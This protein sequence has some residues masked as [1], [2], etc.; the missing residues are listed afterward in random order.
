MRRR[1]W[2]TVGV[3]LIVTFV[4]GL[5]IAFAAG[6]HRTSTA[7][8]RYTSD[9]GGVA[10]ARIIQDDR[11]KPLTPK[12][13]ALPGVES[14][15]SASFVFGG[16]G[17]VGDNGLDALVF[18][19][20]YRISGVRLVEGRAASPTDEHEFV[21]TRK[22]AHVSH[23]QIGDK[24]NLVTMT[25]EQAF[26]NGYDLSDP[27]GPR[28][29]IEMVGIVDGAS[30]LDDGSAIVFVSPALLAENIGLSQTLMNVDLRPG[31]DLTEFRAQLDAA[32]GLSAL[33][34]E[35][36]V[37]ISEAVR[38]AVDAQ[39]RGLWILTAV[40]AIAAVAVLGQVLS[41]QV[42]PSQ[43][44]RER[45]S[46]IGFTRSQVLAEAIARAVIPITI[47][48]LL[49]AIVA[50]LSSDQ[51]PM[52]FARVLEPTPGLRVEWS[53]VLAGVAIFIVALTAWTAVA[54]VFSGRASRV[55]RPSPLVEALATRS[56]SATA[57][58][59]LRLA[60]TRQARERGSVRGS[61]AGVLLSVA[62]VVAAVI[63]GVSL[64]RLVHQPFRYGSNF[65]AS[66]G[67]T[68]AGSLPDGMVERLDADPDVTSLTLFANS[69]A[70]SGDRTILMLGIEPVRG[71]GQPIMLEGRPPTSDD[72]IAFGRLTAAEIGAHVGDTIELAGPTHSQVYRVTGLAVVPGSGANDG[73][74][75][76]GIVTM[77]G[78]ARLDGA[79]RPTSAVVNLRVSLEQFISSVPE[80]ANLPPTPSH[81]S[82]AIANVARVRAIPFMLA[83]VLAALALLTVG[84]VMV[85][86]MRG[87][88]RDF[89]ILR[90]LGAD[91][92]WITSAVHWQATALTA[93]PVVI[94]IPLGIE[95]G[96][97]VFG[98]F[99]DSMGAVP[100]PAIPFVVIT[101]GALAVVTV[102]NCVAA[103]VSHR[104]R[105]KEPALLLQG[106]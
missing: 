17:D 93:L 99:A 12:V 38:N 6:A 83:A 5:V 82:P 18:A 31:V 44:E 89:A 19:G 98:A 92:R 42:R 49:G 25:P 35:P 105:L 32:P 70:R 104:T 66:V 86:S 69:Q 62:G 30:Q 10:D 26:E 59:G 23:M 20:S 79:A 9:F 50:V 36:D 8:D 76:G 65:A 52:G 61:I 55:V 53:V 33:S 74:G 68:G 96:R 46:A 94:G 16:L 56:G 60:F 71:D 77:S 45:L 48:S 1:L 106:E 15:E 58:V 73:I 103:V 95:I 41:R 80:L 2:A 90:S 7:P 64:D 67:D 40:A 39:A 37:L 22:F 100:D 3:T 87:R 24:V 88:R 57:G 63:F 54:L 11:G 78:L 21:A 72:E 75:S 13:A 4:C 27:Q 84:H 101:V 43:E 91:R 28:L 97:L 34:L 85:T 81:P 102:A 47:G 29:S 51:F 14:V